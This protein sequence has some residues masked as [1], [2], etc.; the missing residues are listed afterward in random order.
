[1]EHAVDTASAQKNN[2]KDLDD[3]METT[4]QSNGVENSSKIFCV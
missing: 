2:L 4:V 1:M 3:T